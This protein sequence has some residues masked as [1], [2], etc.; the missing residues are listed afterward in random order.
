MN[1]FCIG[2]LLVAMAGFAAGCSK[3]ARDELTGQLKQGADTVAE[4][5]GQAS[6]AVAGMSEQV[7]AVVDVG[8]IELQLDGP[9]PLASD[10]CYGQWLTFSDGRPSVLHLQSYSQAERETFP[11]VFIRAVVDPAEGAVF[12]RTVK[13]KMFVQITKEGPLYYTPDS[14]LVD[15]AIGPD[16]DSITATLVQGNLLRSDNGDVVPI[17]GNCVFTLK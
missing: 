8:R 11:S 12:D 2:I 15:M 9:Q 4:K 6:G 13:A 1:R 10:A 5:A 7:T 14:E 17:Q 3:A 16:G